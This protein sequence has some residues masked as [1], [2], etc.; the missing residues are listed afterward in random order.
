MDI[1]LPHESNESDEEVVL[2]LNVIC[3]IVHKEKLLELKYPF[4]GLTLP[5][6]LT[7]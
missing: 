3:D 6:G 5:L 4:A 7:L 2:K 1:L